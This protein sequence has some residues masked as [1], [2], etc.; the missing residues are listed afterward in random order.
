MKDLSLAGVLSNKISN[1]VSAMEPITCAPDTSIREALSILKENN[2][3]SVIIESGGFVKGVFTERD[4]IQKVAG[5]TIN[6]EV[7]TVDKVMVHNVMTATKESSLADVL[8]RMDMGGFR[9]MVVVNRKGSIEGI[10]SIKD[11]V[12]HLVLLTKLS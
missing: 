3:G 2:I 8:Q 12:R 10:L 9:H 1:L 7:A 11:I 5:T 4:F 6:M